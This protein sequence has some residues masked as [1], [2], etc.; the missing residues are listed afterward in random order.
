MFIPVV[1]LKLP[2]TP[3]DSKYPTVSSY[4]KHYLTYIQVMGALGFFPSAY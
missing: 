2:T 1:L 4:K 3:F